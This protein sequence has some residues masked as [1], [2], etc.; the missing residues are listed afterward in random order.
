M[1]GEPFWFHDAHI[2]GVE[3]SGE[4]PDWVSAKDVI[5]EM[6]RRHG[7]VAASAASSNITVRAWN[8]FAPWTAT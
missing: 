8:A 1:A 2:W 4:L 6:L 7:V 5:L 3:L